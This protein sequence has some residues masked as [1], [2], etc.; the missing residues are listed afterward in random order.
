MAAVEVSDPVDGVPEADHLLG[1]HALAVREQVDQRGVGGDAD[2]PALVVHGA[3]G[4]RLAA[5][6]RPAGCRRPP[7]RRRPRRHRSRCAAPPAPGPPPSARSASR[8]WWSTPAGSTPAP[9]CRRWPPRPRA[10]APTGRADQHRRDQQEKHGQFAWHSGPLARDPIPVVPA[11]T[12]VSARGRTLALRRSRVSMAQ[13]PGFAG[14]PASR[15][16]AAGG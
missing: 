11:G 14:Q 3:V 12:R 7:D 2:R 10:D 6:C 4:G 1:V 5:G 15:P 16:F 9:H 13:R 8:R